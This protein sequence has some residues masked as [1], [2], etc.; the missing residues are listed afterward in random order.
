M[1]EGRTSTLLLDVLKRMTR[2]GEAPTVARVESVE[3][4]ET[5]KTERTVTAQGH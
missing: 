3:T 2:Q 4:K 1:D 5:E